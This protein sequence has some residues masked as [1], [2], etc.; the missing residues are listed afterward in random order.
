MKVPPSPKITYVFI[1]DFLVVRRDGLLVF[2][3]GGRRGVLSAPL[4][5]VVSSFFF[6]SWVNQVDTTGEMQE[7]FPSEE[8]LW[9]L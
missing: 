4:R 3:R 8:A 9:W 1:M 2:G 7:S 6:G 5:R